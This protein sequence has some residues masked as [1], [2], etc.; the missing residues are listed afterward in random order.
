MGNGRNRGSRAFNVQ[1][2]GYG[3]CEHLARTLPRWGAYLCI[4]AVVVSA[5]LLLCAKVE[6][7]RYSLLGVGVGV[8]VLYF[9]PSESGI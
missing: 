3:S 9:C 7:A 1:R 2:Y 4:I 6:K 5:R 8:L